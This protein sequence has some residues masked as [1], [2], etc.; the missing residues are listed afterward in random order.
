MQTGMTRE[1]YLEI[2]AMLTSDIAWMLETWGYDGDDW[3]EIIM[4][5]IDEGIYDDYVFELAAKCLLRMNKLMNTQDD[6][7]AKVRYLRSV[8]G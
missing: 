6:T 8:S 5:E 4:D 2:K 3:A 1:Q 7:G